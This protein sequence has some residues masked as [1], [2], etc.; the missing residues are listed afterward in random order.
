MKR[1]ARELV[2]ACRAVVF[3]VMVWL[4]GLGV[5]GLPAQGGVGSLDEV[6]G[7][8]SRC[9]I[10]VD[11]VCLEGRGL[12]LGR[13]VEAGMRLF[14]GVSRGRDNGVLVPVEELPGRVGKELSKGV[15]SAGGHGAVDEEESKSQEHVGAPSYDRPSLRS[16]RPSE[17]FVV[18]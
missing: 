13:L 10:A 1:V 3:R 8:S 18:M 4:D 6:V 9:K 16:G 17:H 5:G 14:R 12:V 7:Q 2:A 11:T 15:G